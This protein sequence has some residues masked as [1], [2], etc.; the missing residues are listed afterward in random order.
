M[1]ALSFIDSGCSGELC[2]CGVVAAG[3]FSARKSTESSVLSSGPSIYGVSGYLCQ[4]G[5]IPCS[6][7]DH[8]LDFNSYGS[9]RG[10]INERFNSWSNISGQGANDRG[11]SYP[12]YSSIQQWIKQSFVTYGSVNPAKEVGGDTR[13]PFKA[14]IIDNVPHAN[15]GPPEFRIGNAKTGV[16]TDLTGIPYHFILNMNESQA[17]TW[18]LSIADKFGEYSPLKVGSAYSNLMDEKP[19]GPAGAYTNQSYGSSAYPTQVGM[20]VAQSDSAGSGGS[21]QEQINQN[22]TKVSLDV[23]KELFV[24]ANV[25]LKPWHFRGIGTSFTS[26][27]NWQEKIFNFAW[28][29]TDYSILANKEN[30]N[31]QTVRSGGMLGTRTALSVLTEILNTYGLRHDL[32]RFVSDDFVIPFMNRMNGV[33][34][35]WITQI[36]QCLLYEWHMDNGITFTP[37]LAGPLS[38]NAPYIYD[39]LSASPNFSHTFHE[40]AI[41]EETY[42][43]SLQA[44]YNQVIGV[45]A[46]QGGTKK[47][48]VECFEFGDTYSCSFNPP[49]SCVS[50]RPEFA[51]N[52]FFSNFKFYKGDQLV[53]V[54]DVTSGSANYGLNV[55]NSG[56]LVGIT[57]VTFTW[58]VLPGGFIGLGAPGRISFSGVEEGDDGVLIGSNIDQG[59]SNPAPQLRAFSE[60]RAL[61]NAYGLRPIELSASSLI[62]SQFVLQKF[63]DRM[64]YKLSRQARKGTY[65]IPLNPFIKPGSVIREVDISL[66]PTI[67][68]P[69][70]RDRVVQSCTHSFCDNPANRYTVYTGF[71]YVQ[72]R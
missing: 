49:L 62:P 12:S 59:P 30:Q 53:A 14:A 22:V 52:G 56:I 68:E 65:K 61:I 21:S 66:G 44:I 67:L 28:K 38:G 32:S 18:S 36:L 15:D 40:M 39:Q 63:V 50:H 5:S 48:E 6:A 13:G 16:Y 24:T 71:E 51:N 2:R 33:P 10:K 8:H 54:Q 17:T 43:A 11:W 42:E 70:I 3:E 31:M 1:P 37:Y 58:G 60:N 7:W 27:R 69:L 55:L 26:N 45:R 47:Y 19:F 4:A 34:H 25:G 9:V 35:D 41:A 64:L 46:A 20:A 23:V 57:S 29:G 72:T